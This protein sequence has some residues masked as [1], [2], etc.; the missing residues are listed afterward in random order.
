VRLLRVD[1]DGR[2]IE[3][4]PYLTVLHGLPPDLR[5]DFLAFMDGLPT[6]QVAAV[7]GF[8]EAHGVVLNLNADS[9]GLLDLSP[10]LPFEH[11]PLDVVVRAGQL[12]GAQLSAEDRARAELDWQLEQADKAL[13]DAQV[14]YDHASYTLAAAQE[15]AEMALSGTSQ[16]A[17]PSSL[18]EPRA[19]LARRHQDRV[20][21]EARLRDVRDAQK[22]AAKSE[23]QAHAAVS[24]ARDA[25]V[26]AAQQVNTAAGAL[27]AAVTER[28][29]FAEAALEAARDRVGELEKTVAEDEAARAGAERPG[30][31]G[32]TAGGGKGLWPGGPPVA[33]VVSGAGVPAAG[34]DGELADFDP[35]SGDD[36]TELVNHLEARQAE[37]VARLLAVETV[38]P[39]PVEVALRQMREGGVEMV[40][41]KR[42]ASLADQLAKLNL[43]LEGER[44]DAGGAALAEA[45]HRHD[46]ASRRVGQAE[47]AAR[48]PDLDRTEVETLEQAH[49]QVLEA[50][51]RLDRRPNGKA[52]QRLDEAIAAQD[53]LVERLG[54]RSYDDYARRSALVVDEAK[55]AELEAARAELAAAEDLV[56]QLESSLDAELDLAEIFGRRRVLRMEAVEL[57]GGDPGVDLLWALRHHKEAA[58]TEGP[59]VERLREAMESVGLMVGG[60]AISGPSLEELAEVWLSEQLASGRNQRRLRTELASVKAELAK[61]RAV[62]RVWQAARSVEEETARRERLKVELAE[63][64]EALAVAEKRMAYNEEL[65]ARLRRL[66]AELERAAE[67][68][69]PYIEA[70][71]VAEAAEVVAAG[72]AHSTALAA[73]A[74]A[75]DLATAVECERDADEFLRL[76]ERRLTEARGKAFDT[77]AL[78]AAE[79]EAR[80]LAE[81]AEVALRAAEVAMSSLSAQRT[82]L[83]ATAPEER[84]RNGE[85]VD[86]IEWYILGRGAAVRSVTYAGSLPLAL[87]D[88][89]GVLAA[90]ERMRVLDR[91]ERMASAVQLVVLTDDQSVADWARS[92]GPDRAAVVA[93][94]VLA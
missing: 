9:L 29:P 69:R 60:E 43:Q 34:P 46:R 7:A 1:L 33:G 94:R 4:H 78:Q 90:Q 19:E 23:E 72:L 74:L 3:L 54:F 2:R 63:A 44:G 81:Q 16:D 58:G 86:E 87:D 24:E 15:A 62:A 27:E 57:L 55:E 67:Q 51:D 64:R 66:R 59:R 70:V 77:E 52:V 92:L 25:R 83:S 14:D 40:P 30:P 38:D 8:V 39:L 93:S 53:R 31:A 18:D 65:E 35:G 84:E 76:I 22:R 61:A 80:E 75:G 50:K 37:L 42:A 17:H 6:G 5:D 36:P 79:D 88:V 73:A 41:S 12:P 13:S 45:R 28:D 32:A 89:L 68:E 26:A 56:A 21:L 10:D 91:L 47:Q 71:T 49:A 48:L 20:I 85:L 82:V 11:G